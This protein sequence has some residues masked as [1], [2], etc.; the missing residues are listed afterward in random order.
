MKSEDLGC[1]DAF[2]TMSMA[3]AK[4]QT[5]DRCHFST[6]LR[7]LFLGQRHFDRP[8]IRTMRR[9]LRKQSD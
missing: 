8:S 2:M 7:C 9:K 5:N 4:P 1:R 3:A 6:E